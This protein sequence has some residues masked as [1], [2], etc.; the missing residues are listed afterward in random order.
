MNTKKLPLYLENPY[1]SLYG[2][3]GERI[4]AELLDGVLRVGSFLIA[5]SIHEVSW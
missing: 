3:F 1:N 5:I 4:A 2:N